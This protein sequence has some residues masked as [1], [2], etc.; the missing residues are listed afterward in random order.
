MGQITHQTTPLSRGLQP[1]GLPVTGL[2]GDR[3]LC[4]D[5]ILAICPHERKDLVFRGLNVPAMI[6]EYLHLQVLIRSICEAAEEG[7]IN[8]VELILQENPTLL[9]SK[10]ESGAMPLHVAAAKGHRNVAELFIAKGAKINAKDHEGQT[11]LHHAALNNHMD[12]AE[13]LISENAKL[14]VKNIT[15]LTPLALARGSKHGKM[16]E[17]LKARGAKD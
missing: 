12:I 13:L 16:I 17:L 10:D 2:R 4:E 3:L 11:P 5:S 9:N 14:N 6:I 15:G 8:K 7:D 1:G